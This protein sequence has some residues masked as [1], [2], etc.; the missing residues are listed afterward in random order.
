MLW[1]LSESGVIMQIKL[2]RHQDI[3]ISQAQKKL[4]QYNA[5]AI[6]EGYGIGKTR[7][8]LSIINT[9]FQEN[10]GLKVLVVAPKINILDNSTWVTQIQENLPDIT[11][12]QYLVNKV[13]ADAVITLINYE[14]LRSR[15]KKFITIKW[16]LII[17][18]ESV[19]IKNPKSKV[20]KAAKKLIDKQYE[21]KVML[22]AGTLITEN[23]SELWSQVYVMDRGLSLKSSYY[24]YLTT[25]FKPLVYGYGLKKGSLEKITKKIKH[26]IVHTE[27]E[28]I[29]KFP[30][31]KT[32]YISVQA[33]KIQL[34]YFQDLKND[35]LVIIKDRTFTYKYVMPVIDLMSQI[36]SGFV[37]T[38]T[39]NSV[40]TFPAQKDLILLSIVKKHKSEKKIIWCKYRYE[41]K[42]LSNILQRYNPIIAGNKLSENIEKFRVSKEHNILL[43]TYAFLHPGENFPYVKYSIHYNYPF[44]HHQF[45]NAKGR[46]RRLDSVLYHD[47]IHYIYLYTAGTIESKTIIKAHNKKRDLINE[48][49]KYL[50]RWSNEQ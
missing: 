16:D 7:C 49:K 41:L 8:A 2:D 21:T 4:D 6:M 17:F 31:I 37:Y 43:G 19:K 33:T 34:K 50:W 18:D 11:F 36:T 3:I 24:R 15:V 5:C 46:I 30:K 42:K 38:H 12:F 26:L 23:P 32:E 22:M 47:T 27:S 39:D 45:I 20:F 10:P 29:I 35:F 1:T 40:I 9:M 14:M 25:Y 44:S 13:Y 28:K 48:L